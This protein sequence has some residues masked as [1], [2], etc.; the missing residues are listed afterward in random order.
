MSVT[1]TTPPTTAPPAD[2]VHAALDDPDTRHNLV[3]IARSRHPGDQNLI[4]EVVQE[5]C[6]RAWTKRASF[7]PLQGSVFA[8]LT[9]FLRNI[10]REQLRKDRRLPLRPDLDLAEVAP[11]RPG[12]HDTVAE[13]RRMYEECVERLSP[14]EREV[15]HLAHTLGLRGD[16]IAARLGIAKPAARQRVSRAMSSLTRLVKQFEG[17]GQ[18]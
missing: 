10:Y 6:V 8:W 3:R 16:E 17:E 1:G 12:P 18:S 11:N 9:G 13:R 5:V 14:G 7:D 15:L 4:D 2:L